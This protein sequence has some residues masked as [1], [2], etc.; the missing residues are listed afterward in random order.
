MARQAVAVEYHKVVVDVLGKLLQVGKCLAV[1]VQI[2]E[3]EACEVF[4]LEGRCAERVERS[5]QRVGTE[6]VGIGS[7]VQYLHSTYAVIVA[8]AGFQIVKLYVVFDV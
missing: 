3:D 4:V 5:A 7:L 8:C 6:V 1:L 2:V